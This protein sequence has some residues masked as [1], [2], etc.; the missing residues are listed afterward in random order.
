MDDPGKY[1]HLFLKWTVVLKS[2]ES[3]FQKNEQTDRQGRSHLGCRAHRPRLSLSLSLSQDDRL[4]RA[5]E[6]A[7]DGSNRLDPTLRFCLDDRSSDVAVFPPSR[8]CHFAFD[9]AE[10]SHGLPTR[11]R[12][13]CRC[14]GTLLLERQFDLAICVLAVCAMA[15]TGH[16]IVAIT[17]RARGRHAH[18]PTA[19]ACRR[20]G[21][22]RLPYL[23]VAVPRSPIRRRAGASG[24][25]SFRRSRIA[26][27]CHRRWR[28]PL[29][30]F[31]KTIPD[32]EEKRKIPP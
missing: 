31:R 17:A 8:A 6:I 9:A 27:Q 1:V 19:A 20:R 11:Q 32:S 2:Q 14:G 5:G 15:S 25:S 13:E 29:N 30:E 16:S 3:I 10:I 21:R 12:L 26:S 4:V 7:V 18:R 28:R 23:C 22:T 24:A